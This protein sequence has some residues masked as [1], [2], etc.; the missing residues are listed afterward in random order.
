MKTVMTLVYHRP[1]CVVVGLDESF[2]KMSSEANAPARSSNTS[3]MQNP[4]VYSSRS[5]ESIVPPSEQST[6]FSLCSSRR[7]P[8]CP[9]NVST[10]L[11]LYTVR[12]NGQARKRSAGKYS[13]TPLL[14][15]PFLAAQRGSCQERITRRTWSRTRD[16]ACSN[17]VVTSL[18]RSLSLSGWSRETQTQTSLAAPPFSS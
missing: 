5:F 8:K 9:S 14:L 7:S 11:P 3:R 15:F 4:M 6:S 13:A 2:Q 17:E 12:F 1:V 18:S 10:L 16:H